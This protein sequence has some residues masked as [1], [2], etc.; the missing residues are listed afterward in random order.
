VLGVVAVRVHAVVA[1]DAPVGV[2]VAEV[3]APQPLDVKGV[4]IA[5]GVVNGCRILD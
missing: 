4:L 2:V 3:L 1:A 5:V